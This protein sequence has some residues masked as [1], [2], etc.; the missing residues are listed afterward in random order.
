MHLHRIELLLTKSIETFQMGLEDLGS[1]QVTRNEM[2][3]QD[4]DLFEHLNEA[5]IAMNH[6]SEL[7]N[8]GLTKKSLQSWATALEAIVP[9]ATLVY[10]SAAEHIIDRIDRIA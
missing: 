10:L 5:R 3:N 9:P 1:E 6:L 4:G 2:T 8:E 7:S